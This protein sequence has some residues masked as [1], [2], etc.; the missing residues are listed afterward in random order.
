MR[1]TALAVT[2]PVPDPPADHEPAQHAT[3]PEPHKHCRAHGKRRHGHGAR[4]AQ[5]QAQERAGA[6]AELA[7]SSTANAPTPEH[8]AGGQEPSS[9]IADVCCLVS[10]QLPV[11]VQPLR[12]T[13]RPL[14][15]S[16]SLQPSPQ[17]AQAGK[18]A[19][20]PGT[21]AAY[22]EMQEK[23]HALA[24]SSMPSTPIIR[25]P[26]YTAAELGVSPSLRDLLC[27]VPDD[28]SDNEPFAYDSSPALL[29]RTQQR[30]PQQTPSQQQQQQNQQQQQQQQRATQRRLKGRS[31]VVRQS[32]AKASPRC[33]ISP[34]LPHAVRPDRFVLARSESAMLAKLADEAEARASES[35]RKVPRWAHSASVSPSL[36]CSSQPASASPACSSCAVSSAAMA[37]SGDSSRSS[38]ATQQLDNSAPSPSLACEPCLL[39]HDSVPLSL[40]MTPCEGAGTPLRSQYSRSMSSLPVPDFSLRDHTAEEVDVGGVK[41]PVEKLPCRKDFFATVSP[42][43]AAELITQRLVLPPRHWLVVLDAR[44]QHEYEGGHIQGALNIT[45]PDIRGKLLQLVQRAQH[46]DVRCVVLCHC[47]FSSQRGPDLLRALRAVETDVLLDSRRDADVLMPSE[48]SRFQHLFLIEGGYERFVRVR[49]D[50]CVPVGG[51]VPQNDPRFHDEELAVKPIYE[52][53]IAF[54]KHSQILGRS[55][56]EGVAELASRASSSAS[57]TTATSAVTT[58]TASA[59]AT[60][61]A[62]C[63]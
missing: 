57:A 63:G 61:G 49:P 40:A 54:A 43:T 5:R 8:G 17:K 24:I 26:D 3:S 60:A 20:T 39:L 10:P 4:A 23:L 6:D 22:E 58:S 35:P 41:V 14:K 37:S 25:T 31:M 7:P 50:L 28:A 34:V 47:E 30:Q 62:T 53:D 1:A 19:M 59:S 42:E 18:G 48:Q 29:P 52:R 27:D 36:H 32:T 9:T 15:P 13:A 11:R 44:R 38:S 16:Y 33:S 46:D 51:Y 12:A 45:S 2:G 55:T 56:S 21:E